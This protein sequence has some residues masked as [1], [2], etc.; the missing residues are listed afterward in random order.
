MSA[1]K[2]KLKHKG[3]SS[4]SVSVDVI[5]YIYAFFVFI[6]VPVVFVRDSIDGVQP[7]R[8]LMMSTFLPVLALM[9]FLSGLWKKSTSRLWKNPLVAAMAIFLVITTTSMLWAVN[10]TEA[11]FDVAK[12]A[13]FFVFTILSAVLLFHLPDWPEKLTKFI[14]AAAIISLAVGAVQYIRHV[15]GAET[16]FLDDGR[17]VI[18]E[19]KGLMAHKNQYAINLMLMLPF[20]LYGSIVFKNYWKKL[21]LSVLAAIIV[22]IILV[23]T[24]SVWT[25]IVFATIV[26]TLL[27]ALRRRSLNMSLKQRNLMLIAVFTVLF[28]G[29]AVVILIPANDPFSRLAQ[30]KSI[31]K[32][33]AGNNIY[34]LKI[35]QITGD[36]IVDHPVKGVGAGN[37]KLHAAN[38]FSGYD[39]KKGQ[40]NWLRPH[41][42]PLWVFAEKGIIGILSYAAVFLLTL[43]YLIRTFFIAP[44][45]RRR[46]IAL[47]VF[48][49]LITY[50]I[51]SL[52]S[53]PLERIN[54]QIYL[55]LFT[56]AAVQLNFGIKPES[57]AKNKGNFGILFLL[58]ALVIFPVLY[59]QAIVKSDRRLV[60][61]R[62]ALERSAWDALL[63]EIEGA[64]TWARN[65]DAEATPLS[66]YKGLALSGLGK[67]K[68]AIDAYQKAHQAHP[69]KITV[70]H[71]MAVV[72][73][74]LEDYDNSI[75][76]FEK[77]LDILP[78]YQESLEGLAATYVQLGQ[79]QKT[80]HLL[81]RINFDQRTETTKQNLQ[82][83]RRLILR[84]LV[85]DAL[86]LRAE[87]R[88][89][90]AIQKF[91]SA[92]RVFHSADMF[93]MRLENDH[94][95]KLDPQTKL[96]ALMLM[97]PYRRSEDYK[98]KV[99]QLKQ[100]IADGER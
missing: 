56:A 40:L 53:F 45:L 29:F 42:D 27:A 84:E 31:A 9:L 78:E 73:N 55:F 54:Q 85:E 18:Y 58:M 90:E 80:L 62:F 69:T 49:G 36:M 52:F 50:H 19:V 24:R 95:A 13:L 59:S 68:L 22:M 28:A 57:N 39:L 70:L 2:K 93:L 76:Y 98:R 23:H 87:G 25:A 14:F 89:Q 66:W 35:W 32:A 34:R 33:D 46:L 92:T 8:M 60:K 75:R 41:N 12:T 47:L 96:E 16:G 15:A 77:A 48:G 71:N 86:A 94:G 44:D 65:L 26:L 79:Y 37:W 63:R 97:P 88:Q 1:K 7:V 72:Y 91:D 4:A 64:E 38:Y 74:R 30:L 82:A 61:A 5:F 20:V 99:R 81:E 51:T 10:I 17:P 43:F 11:Y 6:L 83:S 100:Q 3:L 67:P 21:S